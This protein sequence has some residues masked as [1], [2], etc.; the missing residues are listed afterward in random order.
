I[1]E[2]SRSQ[3]VQIVALLLSVA[4]AALLLQYVRALAVLRME[5]R[6]DSAIQAGV[7]D[8]LLRLPVQFFRRFNAGD[9]AIRAG[10]VGQIR[11]MLSTAVTT[12]ALTGI[13]SAWYLALLFYYDVRMALWVTAALGTLTFISMLLGWIQLRHLRRA[14]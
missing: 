12:A 8:H 2:A 6:L 13:F 10:G 3:L 9:L 1:P 4:V 5:T 11:Q 7:W 14:T